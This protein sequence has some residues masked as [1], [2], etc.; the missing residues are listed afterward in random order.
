MKRPYREGG[1]DMKKRLSRQE[2]LE[3]YANVNERSVAWYRVNGK[4]PDRI[5]QSSSLG[6]YVVGDWSWN[7]NYPDRQEYI[8]PP[9]RLSPPGERDVE[10]RRLRGQGETLQAI[11]DKFGLTRERVRQIVSED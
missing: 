9:K 1:R 6:E 10:I 8:K 7:R 11:G 2:L 5:H 4:Y 3:K